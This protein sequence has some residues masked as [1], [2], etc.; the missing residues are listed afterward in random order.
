MVIPITFHRHTKHLVYYTEIGKRCHYS[1][2]IPDKIQTIKPKNRAR[3]THTHT[4]HNRNQRL[5][6]MSKDQNSIKKFPLR[7]KR[8]KL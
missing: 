6:K 2:R 4:Y 5:L 8:V 7:L 1:D 3:V